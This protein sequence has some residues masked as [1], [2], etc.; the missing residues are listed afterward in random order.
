[1]ICSVDISKETAK[2][3][4]LTKKASMEVTKLLDNIFDSVKEKLNDESDEEAEKQSEDNDSE[5]S[6]EEKGPTLSKRTFVRGKR[7]LNQTQVN[8]SAPTKI[9]KKKVAKK[10]I[11]ES[12]NDDEFDGALSI[13]N[14]IGKKRPFPANLENMS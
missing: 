10:D 12:E 1:V 9:P 13:K 3:V 5:S 7:Q 2:K 4:I 14:Q 6:A 8:K 11:S